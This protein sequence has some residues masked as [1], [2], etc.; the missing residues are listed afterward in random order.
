MQR[1]Y[2]RVADYALARIIDTLSKDEKVSNIT[3]GMED[4]EL[5]VAFDYDRY[6][7]ER[8]NKKYPLEVSPI[9]SS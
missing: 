3:I 8:R 1:Y 9:H 7:R 4:D 5:L 2:I 6:A